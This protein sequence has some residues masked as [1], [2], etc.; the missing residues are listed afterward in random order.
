MLEIPSNQSEGDTILSLNRENA[1]AEPCEECDLACERVS[2][3]FSFAIPS[4]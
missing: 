4:V 2:S 1:L 3:L